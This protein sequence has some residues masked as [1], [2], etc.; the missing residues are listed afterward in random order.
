[1]SCNQTELW[2]G[3][4][5]KTKTQMPQKPKIHSN[6][7]VYLSWNAKGNF[8]VL[9]LSIFE[10][11]IC[12]L[13]LALLSSALSSCLQSYPFPLRS[14]QYSFFRMGCCQFWNWPFLP[15]ALNWL[16]CNFVFLT[17]IKRRKNK[18]FLILWYFNILVWL[19]NLKNNVFDI[20]S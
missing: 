11:T 18:A 20:C 16:Y 15:K 6:Q 12:F 8:F 19:Y 13:V 14:L 7:S 9:T 10:K 1:M 17:A 3:P 5:F 4:V 2:K